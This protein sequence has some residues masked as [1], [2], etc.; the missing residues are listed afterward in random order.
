MR[1]WRREIRELREAAAVALE[2]IFDARAFGELR[3]F[4]GDAGNVLELAEEEYAHAHRLILSRGRVNEKRR[5]GDGA[6]LM[7]CC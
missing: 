6:G 1:R 5:H 4:L 7:P 3:L 2:E